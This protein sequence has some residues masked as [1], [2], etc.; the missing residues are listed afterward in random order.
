VETERV[1]LLSVR[2]LSTDFRTRSGIGRAVD[3]VSFDIA[4][5]EIV[6]IV[7]ES[8]SGKSVTAM[9]ILGLTDPKTSIVKADEITF[10]GDRI[11]NSVPSRLAEVRGQSIGL[12]L[13]DPQAAL[14]P[15][16]KIST[17]LERVIR[18]RMKDIGR[19][20]VRQEAM[21][22]MQ[23]LRIPDP[24]A[25]LASFPHQLS[26]GQKQRIVSAIALAGSPGLIIAD[27]PTTSLDVTVQASY[28]ELLKSIQSKRS[29]AVCLITHDFTVVRSFADRVIVMYAGRIVEQ[30]RTSEI[31]TNPRHPYTEGLL[32]SLPHEGR[33]RSDSSIKGMPPSIFSENRQLCMFSSRC[34]HALPTCFTDVPERRIFDDGGESHCWKPDQ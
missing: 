26:G 9:S 20:E 31:F 5:G 1:P 32:R 13:Q 33:Y 6:A 24:E 30:N 2:N 16:M 29:M 27:E 19:A 3:G 14:N 7:G 25:K 22:L 15:A 17:Q 21:S 11:D 12:V 23:L 34:E 28:L 8:G 10:R 18:L 4:E